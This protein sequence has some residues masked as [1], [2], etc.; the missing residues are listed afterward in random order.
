MSSPRMETTDTADTRERILRETLRL[1]EQR[2]G[3]G[4]R[5]E[6]IA[7]AARVSRQ[8][9]YLHFGSRTELL[10]AT[11]RYLDQRLRLPE[12]LQGVFREQ[13][14]VERVDACTA[15][16]AAYI[17][18]IYGL[19]KALLTQRGTDEAAAA[20]W[21]DRMAALYQGCRMVVQCLEEEGLLAP[22]WTADAAADFFW[23]ALS[24]ETWEHLTMDRGWTQEQY[25]EQMQRAIKRALL[26]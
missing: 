21:A 1:M 24:I 11:A 23:A 18:E 22:E 8:A 25:L 26:K 7:Q 16:W 5:I 20:A 14:A 12:R 4:V 3:Q 2:R 19:A 17:P 15:F 13:S 10:I 6:D 9:V